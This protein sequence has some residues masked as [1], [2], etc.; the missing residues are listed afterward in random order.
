MINILTLQTKL[1]AI[2]A[3]L[4]HY[5]QN[6]TDWRSNDSIFTINLKIANDNEWQVVIYNGFSFYETWDFEEIE[7]YLDQKNIYV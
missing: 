2:Q 5:F 3:F 4:D 7:D 6:W 1:K